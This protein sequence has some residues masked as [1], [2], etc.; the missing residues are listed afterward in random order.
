MSSARRR[1][2]DP[3]HRALVERPPHGAV[4]V[5][6][7]R[8]REAQLARHQRLRLDDVD[9][10]LVEAALVGDLDDVAETVGGDQRRAR[11]LALDDGVGGERGAVHQHA[12]VGE[13]EA[14]GGQHAARAL[15]DGHL[16]RP[17]RGQ[18][19]GDEAALP[20]QQHDVGEGAADIDGQPGRRMLL[21]HALSPLFSPAIRAQGPVSRKRCHC[22]GASALPGGGCARRPPHPA[23][24]ATFSPRGEGTGGAVLPLSP[25]ETSA[26]LHDAVEFDSTLSGLRRD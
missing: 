3:A 5:H 26:K 15:D 20:G 14:R 11:A 10:V 6:A 16:R 25:R 8:H 17:R 1:S 2:R 19:L 21:A 18:H 7:L 23:L 13:G 22:Q 12:D 4:H 24:R 9:V